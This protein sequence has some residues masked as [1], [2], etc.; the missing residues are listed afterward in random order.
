[1][2]KNS[3]KVSYP[4]G[5][6]EF[7]TKEAL[8]AARDCVHSEHPQLKTSTAESDK[9]TFLLFVESVRSFIFDMRVQ[10]L[11]EAHGGKYSGLIR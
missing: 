5:K 11:V 10:S 7:S 4:R 2:I 9:G 8:N 6:F 1:M 3:K